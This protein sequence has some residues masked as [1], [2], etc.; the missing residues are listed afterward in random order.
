MPKAIGIDLGTSNSCAA[1]VEEGRPQIIVHPSGK[2]SM[3]SAFTLDEEGRPIIGEEA[4]ESEGEVVIA[5][6]RLIGRNFHSK[7]MEQI[8]QLFTYELLPGAEQEVLVKI[9]DQLFTLEQ[10]SA[11]IIGNLRELAQ[12]KLG[13]QIGH[14]V[15]TVPA[16]FNEKQRQA[17]REAGRLA[18]LEVL[19]VINEPT[20]AAL[21]YGFQRTMEKRIAVFDLGGGTFDVSV[22]DI[23]GR[24]FE[25][26]A[27]GGNN[28]LGGVDFDGRL[29][30]H[31]LETF[32]EE[33]GIDLS[34][35]RTA[36]QRIRKAAEAAKIQLSECEQ[37]QVRLPGISDGEVE[38]DLELGITR[39]KL[40]ALTGDLVDQTIECCR[41]LLSETGTT[42][43]ELDE[44]LLVGGQSRM[45]L[46]QR[47]LEAF[48]GRPASRNIHPEEAV[49]QGAALMAEAITNPENTHFTLMDVLPMNIGVR[50]P[51][52]GMQI[53]FPKNCPLPSERTR[54]LTTFKNNQRSIMIRLYQGDN[55]RIEDNELL[56]THVF[57]RLPPAAK[58]ALKIQVRFRIDTEGLLHISAQNKETG[59]PIELMNRANRPSERKREKIPAPAS[60]GKAPESTDP[61]R[62][63]ASEAGHGLPSSKESGA[64][65]GASVEAPEVPAV[66]AVSH[67]SDEA[68]SE[69]VDGQEAAKESK[70]RSR[71][72]EEDI[73]EDSLQLPPKRLQS[74]ERTETADEATAPASTEGRE[75][76]RDM[77]GQ[78][79]RRRKRPSPDRSEKSPPGL[80]TATPV[81]L[82]EEDELS[83]EDSMPPLLL[84]RKEAEEVS[85][86]GA[87]ED[88]GGLSAAGSEDDGWEEDSEWDDD[89]SW[90]E[91]S[92]PDFYE[93]QEEAEDEV[94]EV[95][96]TPDREQE[97]PGD[98]APPAAFHLVEGSPSS[99]EEQW[100]P[101]DQDLG[102]SFFDDAGAEASVP[103]GS[104]SQEEEELTV[105]AKLSRWLG[106]LFG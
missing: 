18:E 84:Q 102:S 56:G 16:Y 50:R 49:A 14:A 52:G 59:E 7:S 98:G 2:G 70:D 6:K 51:D 94:T 77:G 38:I 36:V 20:A 12:E 47:K 41:R 61:P 31:I 90:E 74:R 8:R 23:H 15:I 103:E 30:Q 4:Q 9:R 28:Q 76:G 57:Y 101:Q 89:S 33:H 66:P 97:E 3:P 26:I 25:V 105:F 99:G 19:R 83:D 60:P 73:L 71:A 24:V 62:E 35:Q 93:G 69:T 54:V 104:E 87:P 48:Y 68:A 78:A 43:G 21:A 13:M 53:L 58:G 42:L 80:P 72:G 46:V 63:V 75:P 67:V 29:M 64:V 91:D 88:V 79:P 44:I 39:E 82:P 65:V 27:T 86:D 100:S 81:E 11:S 40:E 17:V 5:S 32:L 22:I 92:L 106:G 85:G 1:H 96:E 95:T 34:F 45:P 55:P 10:I 37:V